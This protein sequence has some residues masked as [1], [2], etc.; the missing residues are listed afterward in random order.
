MFKCRFSRIFAPVQLSIIIVNYNVKYFLEQ[1]LFS[2]RR[3]SE[4]IVVETIVVDNRSTDGSMKYLQ[5]KFPEVHFVASE[6]NLGFA[7]ACNRGLK[8]AKGAYILFLNPD[9]L[10]AE[11]TLHRCLNF[12]ATHSGAG[13]LGVRMVDGSGRFLKES[14][15]A[16]PGPLTSLFKLFGLSKIFPRSRVFSRYYLGHLAEHQ[17]HEVDVLAGA[18]MM[19]RHDVLQQVGS[20]DEAFFMYGEDIDLSYRIQQAGFKNYYLAETTIVHFKGESTKRGSLNYVRL[21]YK[22]MSIFVRKH[23]SGTRADVFRAALQFAIWVRAG[24]AG[25]AR[26][27]S[28]IGL[29]FIDALLILFSFWTVKEFWSR[30]IK[31]N[32]AYEARLLWIAFPVFTILFLLVAYYAGLYHKTYRQADLNR[33]TGIATLTL[34][35]GYALLPEQYRFSRGIVVFGALFACVLITLFRRMLVWGG[36][37]HQPEEKRVHP[38]ILVAGSGVEYKAV[39]GLLYKNGKEQ[40]VIGRLSVDSDASGAL[41]PLQNVAEVDAA[42]GAEELVLCAGT[43]SYKEIISFIQCAPTQLRFRFYGTGSCSLVGSDSSGTSG[44]AVAE[45]ENFNLHKLHYRRLKRMVDV[46]ASVL[47]LLLAPLHFLLLRHPAAIIRNCFAV[48]TGQKTWVGY[49]HQTSQLP[50][51]KTPVITTNGQPKKSQSPAA[52]AHHAIDYWYARNYKPRQ[53]IQLILKNY[54]HLQ[55]I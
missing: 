39:Q 40:K 48:L 28:I 8:E 55:G 30:F 5:E 36:R 16:F 51:I 46:G 19:I 25:M 3:A 13:A 17:N 38:Y 54:K 23:Y 21:F 10:L 14:K 12:F 6:T 37:L 32:V 4:G 20:F 22:A 18:F 52:G 11:D 31:T 34:L 35:A 41:A 29:P 27:V 15:R 2:V 24:M 7:R 44:E 42:V 45:A 49:H 50:P 47:L 9:T 1:C 26:L 33:S 43:L 53:D